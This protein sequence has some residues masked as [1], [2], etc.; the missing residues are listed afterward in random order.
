MNNPENGYKLKETGTRYWNDPN[1][2]ATNETG[3]SARG[4]GSYDGLGYYVDGFYYLSSNGMWWTSDIHDNS[5]ST[6][7]STFSSFVLTSYSA[8]IISSHFKPDR[9]LSIRCVKD[10]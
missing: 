1:T 10:N 4:G 6:S 2:G 3:F 7:Q 9:A 5:Y 8:N